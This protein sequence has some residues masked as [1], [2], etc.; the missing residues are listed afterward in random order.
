MTCEARVMQVL[1]SFGSTTN[2]ADAS[3]CLAVRSKYPVESILVHEF[4]HAVKDL[5]MA[6]EDIALVDA[7]HKRA[8]ASGTYDNSEWPRDCP[9]PHV[10]STKSCS[11]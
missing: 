2:T 4:G 10:T 6:A 9:A 3:P 1:H 7:L 5:G 8:R 11:T